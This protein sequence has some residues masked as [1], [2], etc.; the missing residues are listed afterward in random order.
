MFK[1]PNFMD[2]YTL[3]HYFEHRLG[4][5]NAHW[6]LENDQI[7]AKTHNLRLSL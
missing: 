1:T 4:A 2:Y 6:D 5:S 3:I 7:P